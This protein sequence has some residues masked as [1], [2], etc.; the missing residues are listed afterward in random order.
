M[1]LQLRAPASAVAATY[2]LER[3]RR[4]TCLPLLLPEDEPLPLERSSFAKTR[5]E[6]EPEL[7]V[8]EEPSSRRR[9]RVIAPPLLPEPLL[10]PEYERLERSSL[11]AGLTMKGHS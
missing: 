10:L 2:R 8:E 3:R 7:G 5:A 6:V 11:A 4:V 9:R 1:A